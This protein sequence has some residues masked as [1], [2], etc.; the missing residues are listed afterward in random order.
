[1][2]EYGVWVMPTACVMSFLGYVKCFVLP[3]GRI[4]R[5]Y[6]CVGLALMAALALPAGVSRRFGLR[7]CSEVASGV[8]G[9]RGVRREQVAEACSREFGM[10][11]A[12][13]RQ[14]V[15]CCVA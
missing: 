4:L 1:M 6:G 12:A 14:A 11:I 10:A 13:F 2:I 7:N 9:S 8:R 15:A 3:C 5:C